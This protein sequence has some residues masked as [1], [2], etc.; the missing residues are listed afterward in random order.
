MT[1]VAVGTPASGARLKSAGIIGTTRPH[2]GGLIGAQPALKSADHAVQYVDLAPA[3]VSAVKQ[4]AQSPHQGFGSAVG[5]KPR[6]VQSGF[7]VRVKTF[8]PP[9]GPQE[10]P[11]RVRENARRF[12]AACRRQACRQAYVCLSRTP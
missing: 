10:H 1:P 7:K 12:P 2:R 11:D 9:P 5:K 8:R 3:Q 6:P 4:L